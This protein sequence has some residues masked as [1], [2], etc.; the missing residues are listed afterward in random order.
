VTLG[1]CGAV[2]TLWKTS[3]TPGENT[4]GTRAMMASTT[5]H[6]CVASKYGGRGRGGC[7]G[8]RGKDLGPDGVDHKVA[9]AAPR[10]ARRQQQRP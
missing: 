10:C 1:P 3:A 5:C 4:N 8:M 6:E 9:R 2:R 7:G